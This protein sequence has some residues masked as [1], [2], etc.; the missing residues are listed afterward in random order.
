MVTTVNNANNAPAFTTSD[1]VVLYSTTLQTQGC[2]PLEVLRLAA[3]RGWRP[4]SRE[5]GP[6]ATL[7][8]LPNCFA[9][10]HTKAF[11]AEVV[12]EAIDAAWATY[13]THIS[14]QC[15][16]MLGY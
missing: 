13:R 15:A 11:V 1:S 9:T 6:I 4:T 8:Y 12:S 3:A 5:E 10:H 7:G 14:T 2:L 16:N